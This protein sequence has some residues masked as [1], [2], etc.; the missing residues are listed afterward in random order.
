M[1]GFLVGALSYA[2]QVEAWESAA[3]HGN[4]DL[5]TANLE[6]RLKWHRQIRSFQ[7]GVRGAIP[8]SKSKLATA[9]P[10]PETTPPRLAQAVREDAEQQHQ[11]CLA[12]P[13][14]T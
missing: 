9:D 14:D 3:D 13:A 12:S 10:V 4:E 6:G 11:A 2:T 1:Q 8:A 7:A 5:I